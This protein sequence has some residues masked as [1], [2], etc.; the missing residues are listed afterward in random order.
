MKTIVHKWLPRPRAVLAACV[1]V[2]LVGAGFCSVSPVLPI[3]AASADVP[4]DE[5]GITV[6]GSPLGSLTTSPSALTPAFSQTTHDY[7]VACQAGANLFTVALGAQSGSIVVGNRSGASVTTIVQLI[8]GQPLVVTAPDPADPGGTTQYW[9]RCLPHDFPTLTVNRSGATSPGWY[10]TS[11]LSSGPGGYGLYAMILDSNGTPVWYMPT[12]GAA[13]DFKVLRDDTLSWGPMNGP[14]VGATKASWTLYD[15][16]AQTTTA[17]TPPIQP[18]DPHELLPLANGN[19]MSIASPVISGVPDLPAGDTAAGGNVIDCVVQEYDPSGSLVWSWDAYQHVSV[20]EA[21]IG[22]ADVATVAGVQAADIYHCNS[23]DVDPAVAN[24][25]AADV[26]VSSRNTSAV[27]RINRENQTIPNGRVI[28]KLGGTASNLDGAQ[29]LAI[30]G[31]AQTTISGQHDARF[32]PGGDISL[33]DDH[34]GLP[35]AARGLS[36]HLDTTASTA[37]LDFEHKAPDGTSAAATGGFRRYSGGSDNVI[38]WGFHNQP[39]MSEVDGSSQDLLDLSFPTE[40]NLYRLEKLPIGALDVQ[41]LRQT[42]GSSRPNPS[43][44]ESWSAPGELTTSGALAGTGSISGQVRPASAGPNR[45]DSFWKGHDGNLWHA[46]SWDGGATWTGPAG[47]ASGPLG[48]DPHPV[49]SAP[50][51]LDVF[52]R[53]TDNGLWHDWFIDGVGWNG[54]QSLGGIGTMAS[55]P[56]PVSFTST[57]IDVFW[58]GTDGNLWH[59]WYLDGLGW[60]APS[61]LGDGPLGSDPH[62]VLASDFSVDVYW[63]GTDAN[64]WHDWFAG[65]WHGAAYLG[66][67]PLVSDPV[68]VSATPGDVAIFWQGTDGGVWKDTYSSGS[69]WSGPD[70]LGPAGSLGSAPSAVSASQATID[71]FW[72]GPDATLQQMH[73]A[74]GSGWSLF[75]QPSSTPL[76]TD[77][78]PVAVGSG[79]LAVN[80]KAISGGFWFQR[81]SSGAAITS[82]V[83]RVASRP[84]DIARL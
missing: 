3:P 23:I 20:G 1:V 15:L 61:S 68:P 27:Y 71:L 38:A 6:S 21:T 39:S 79:Q 54:P 69:G 42:A 75:P 45:I 17:L 13:I 66:S 64:L 5:V 72:R 22:A 7:T 74:P 57:G 82:S 35:G 50:G 10:V 58:K 28:W 48:A 63:K 78:Q 73:F 55:D 37:T 8:E 25:S 30:K 11:T 34:T 9:I 70:G 32:Q 80:A 76:S 65:G 49:S 51:R 14:G 59:A 26:L 24:P 44:S 18:S 53:G 33:Y 31:D 36:Y 29:I 12:N 56:Y 40:V 46:W 16:D 67:G 2:V 4:G 41:L 60:Q 62:P 47:L 19:Y 43:T 81:S 83:P 84:E 52:W 77:P